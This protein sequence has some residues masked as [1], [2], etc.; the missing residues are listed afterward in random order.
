ML[1]ASKNGVIALRLFLPFQQ[2]GFHSLELLLVSIEI[3]TL[4]F[5][6]ALGKV[7]K[8]DLAS[9]KI[10][11]LLRLLFSSFELPIVGVNLRL[12]LR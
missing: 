4:A 6:L 9:H 10:V 1:P 8:H 5:A 7:L 2:Q 11:R 3:L 12:N